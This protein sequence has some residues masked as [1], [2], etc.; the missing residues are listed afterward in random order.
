MH[1]PYNDSCLPCH[2]CVARHNLPSI[3]RRFGHPIDECQPPVAR[4]KRR[5]TSPENNDG[6]WLRRYESGRY[7]LASFRRHASVRVSAR[8]VREGSGPFKRSSRLKCPAHFRCREACRGSELV[9]SPIGRA[10]GA[11]RQQTARGHH[12]LD[13]VVRTPL[14]GKLWKKPGRLLPRR[15]LEALCERSRSPPCAPPV[16]AANRDRGK[17][18]RSC[19][20]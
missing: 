7:P 14:A 19:R 8:P 1:I 17:R 5:A 13:R 4:A 9:N 3:R 6:R 20:S 18:R 10:P 16:R 15:C 12:H 2:C 11:S